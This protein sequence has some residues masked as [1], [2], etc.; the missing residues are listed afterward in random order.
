MKQR[1]TDDDVA[2]TL[3][4]W[5]FG[6]NSGRLNV[7][8]DGQNFVFSDTLGILRDRLGDIHVTAATTLYPEVTKLIVRWLMDRL[9]KDVSDFA[10]TSINVNC[11]YAAKLHRDKSNFGPSLISAFGDFTGGELGYY[12]EDDNTQNLDKVGA[13]KDKEMTSFS[14]RKDGR[15]NLVLF[16]GNS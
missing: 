10:F 5:Q 13:S 8:P 14:L 12:P 6:K 2:C 16:N 9:P 15:S 1:I 3:K 7:I 11:N 4:D